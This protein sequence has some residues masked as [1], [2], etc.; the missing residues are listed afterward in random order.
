MTP[1]RLAWLRLLWFV[2][3]WPSVVL[4]DHDGEM[5]ARLLRGA[6][7]FRIAHRFGFGIA[8]VR[9]LPQ[10]VVRGASYVSSWEPLLPPAVA[11]TDAN[12]NAP[13]NVGLVS[14]VSSAP[15]HTTMEERG[16]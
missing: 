7:S 5:N 10:G 6:E 15:D 2:F 14:G 9:L 3:R 11:E 13:G 16:R 4:I 8:T 1:L 12:A